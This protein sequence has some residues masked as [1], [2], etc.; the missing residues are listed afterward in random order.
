MLDND[1]SELTMQQVSTLQVEMAAASAPELP[2]APLELFHALNEAGARY[3]LWKSNIRLEQGLRGETDLDVLVDPEDMQ[4]FKGIL[5]EHQVKYFRA[6]PGKDYASMENYLG[7]DPDSGR[8][9]HL[10]VHYQLVLGEQFVKNYRLPLERQF[11]DSA[12]LREGVR[13]PP[14]ELEIIVLSL[15]ILLK[16]R[17]RDVIKDIIGHPHAGISKPF[18]KEID[19]LL[20]QTTRERIVEAA[21][22]VSDVLPG[23]LIMG[24]LDLV[25]SK[26]HA[27]LALYHLRSQVRKTLRAYQRQEGMLAS[28]H[29]FGELWRKW[30]GWQH[31]VQGM[32]LPGKGLSISLVGAD[33]SGKSTLSVLLRKWLSWRV[34]V[35]AHYLGSKQPSWLSSILYLGFRMFRRGGRAVI[36]RLGQASWF[37][38]P[39]ASM[40]QFCLYA[41]FL[42]I[43]RDRY[44]RYVLGNVQA[45]R[46]SIVIFDRFPYRSP[47]D[48]PEIRLRAQGNDGA[49]VRFFAGRE[50]QIYQKFTAADHTILLKVTPEVSQRRK[51]DHT[52]E[53]IRGKDASMGALQAELSAGHASNWSVQDADL[54]L[55]E[56]LLQLKRKVWALL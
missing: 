15:R 9:F 14:P 1:G 17:D 38:R 47:L 18:A 20:G 53:T 2:K 29:Y 46:G 35:R 48:G 31:P 30:L 40:K 8:L 56:V 55:D 19:W 44:R 11:L 49:L 23:D 28:A 16:Y 3:C 26:R 5:G 12:Q 6:A 36:K 13:L 45:A 50:E 4:A 51:P 27:R 52:L 24:F 41:H 42:S 10:H 33:G 54:P 7:F 34:D 43:A 32:T 25:T 22:A 37:V 39:L 21:A